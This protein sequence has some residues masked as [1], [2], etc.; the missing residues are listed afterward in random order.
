VKADVLLRGGPIFGVPDADALAVAGHRILAVGR[1]D[2]LEPLAGAE[3]RVVDLLGRPLLPGFVD[4]HVHLDA[5][6]QSRSQLDVGQAT[7]LAEI[8]RLVAARAA[9][10]PEGVWILGRGWLRDRLERWPT[11][12][13]LDGASPRHPVALSSRD[14]HALWVNSAALE[15]ARVASEAAGAPGAQAVPSELS[16]AGGDSMGLLF[17]S[18]Q[19]LV[20]RAIQP[21]EPDHR[22]SALEEVVSSANALGLVGVHDF[23]GNQT[24]QAF[25]ALRDE[26]RL[27]LRVTMGTTRE[28]LERRDWREL[29]G[30]D[31]WLRIG[32]VKLFAD[33]ALGSRTAA[34]LEPYD[35]AGGRG[36]VRLEGDNLVNLV[37]RARSRGL[38][39]AVHAI[40]DAA[41][42]SVLDAFE[43]ARADDAPAASTQVLRV[44]HAQL[45]DPT[46]LPRFR[47]LGVIV[48]MQPNHCPS[49]RP[50]ATAEWGERCAH[51]YAWRSVLDSGAMLALG[52]DCPVEALDPLLNLYAAITRQDPRGE[53]PGGWYPEQCLTLEQAVR[54]YTIGSAVASGDQTSRGSLQPGKLADLV[55]LSEPI[56]EQPPET[57]LAT[58]VDFTM[59]SGRLVFERN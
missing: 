47:Q 9:I 54:A 22:A 34:L 44:E 32:L 41:V 30:A 4:A 7:G 49:D 48:S 55:V 21:P 20:R 56:F 13:D 24:L 18:A 17:E 29:F 26:G 53:P 2:D 36:H 40:G 15:A 28:F 50:I 5:Y 57:L 6:A 38:G 45:I 46:D 58:R 42:R 25:H 59:V 16:G 12:A 27:R 3:T 8:A 19:D 52:T 35:A 1:A 31:D 43:R 10:L 39:V 14:S 51:A 33:G 11:A 23:E 37:R